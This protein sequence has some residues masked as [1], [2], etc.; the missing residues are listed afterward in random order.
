MFKQS[1]TWIATGVALAASVGLAANS[2]GQHRPNLFEPEHSR[3][4][5]Y[6]VL[7]GLFIL[8]GLF[9]SVFAYAGDFETDPV[10]AGVP[11]VA[12]KPGL[13][14]A[15]RIEMT[16][17]GT[18]VEIICGYNQNFRQADDRVCSNNTLIFTFEDGQQEF[19]KPPEN[20]EPG[21]APIAIEC[22]TEKDNPQNSLIRIVYLSGSY[23]CHKC[24]QDMIFNPA[25][26]VYNQRIRS[27]EI[28]FGS[29]RNVIHLET[30]STDYPDD[31]L[32]EQENKL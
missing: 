13:D 3:H 2:N 14:T 11:Y 10:V 29:H 19:P 18:T 9:F 15:R 25:A 30:R 24:Y 26:E 21:T 27:G 17:G 6:R 28:S 5:S 20:F 16:C 8:F 22:G 7:I 32:Y 4:Y 31:Y 12:A 23:N 1:K